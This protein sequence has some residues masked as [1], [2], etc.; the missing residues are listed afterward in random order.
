[1]CFH[2]SNGGTTLPKRPMRIRAHACV[3]LILLFLCS[4]FASELILE[5]AQSLGSR[6]HLLENLPLSQSHERPRR[7]VKS[8]GNVWAGDGFGINL[9]NEFSQASAQ[10]GPSLSVI[11]NLVD[12]ARQPL[13]DNVPVHIEIYNG[14][15]GNIANRDAKGPTHQFD[16]LPWYGNS[17]AMVIINVWRIDNGDEARRIL[18]QRIAGRT[19]RVDLMILPKRPELHALDWQQLQRDRSRIAE[20]FSIGKPIHNPQNSDPY[21]QLASTGTDSLWWL[22]SFL[23]LMETHKVDQGL[24]IDY[25]KGFNWDSASG[26]AEL[27]LWVDPNLVMVWTEKQRYKRN[28]R[29]HLPQLVFGSNNQ[30]QSSK[31]PAAP[32]PT[33]E[34]TLFEDGSYSKWLKSG[35]DGAWERFPPLEP[36]DAI[37]MAALRKKYNKPE[38][39]IFGLPN[40]YYAEWTIQDRRQLPQTSSH[41]NVVFNLLFRA[42]RHRTISGLECIELFILPKAP[43]GADTLF[44]GNEV[45]TTAMY[46]RLWYAAQQNVHWRFNPGFVIRKRNALTFFEAAMDG[47]LDVIKTY[48]STGTDIESESGTHETALELAIKY[49]REETVEF[50][51]ASGAKPNHHAP[52]VIA[53]QTGNLRI[54]RALMARGAERDQKR[55]GFTPLLAA[56][57]AGNREIVDFLIARGASVTQKTDSRMSALELAVKN[58]KIEVIETLLAHGVN[59]NSNSLDGS[60]ILNLAVLANNVR[61]V[62]AFLRGGADPNAQQGSALMVAAYKGHTDVVLALLN[63]GANPN[64]GTG[65]LFMAAADGYTEIVK[66]LLD[67][68]AKPNGL[69][70]NQITPLML[71]SFHGHTEIVNLLLAKGADVNIKDTQYGITAL[72]AAAREGTPDVVQALLAR[73]ADRSVRV[74]GKT[75]LDFAKQSGNREAAAVVNNAAAGRFTLQ[76][77][78]TYSEVGRNP[79]ALRRELLESFLFYDLELLEREASDGKSLQLSESTKGNLK[80]EL[81]F[82]LD[83]IVKLY[84]KNRQKIAKYLNG[85]PLPVLSAFVT[86]TDNGQAYAGSVAPSE[87]QTGGIF[88]D[89]K[90]LKTNM[91]TTL[92]ESF[93][94]SSAISEQEQLQKLREI[95][96][97]V[98]N[99]LVINLGIESN[100]PGAFKGRISN[101][102]ELPRTL[103]QI[104]I[105]TELLDLD[106]QVKRAETQYY[107]TILFVLAHELG[108]LAL[109]HHEAMN[110]A[111]LG[112]VCEIREQIEK[113]ADQFSALLLGSSFIALSVNVLPVEMPG[114]GKSNLRF[115]DNKMLQRYVGYSLFFDKAYERLDLKKPQGDECYPSPED[116]LQTAG[117]AVKS[118][119]DS[120]GESIVNKIQRRQDIKDAVRSAF[121]RRYGL[122]SDMLR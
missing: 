45:S 96:R 77:D 107:G 30:S 87:N 116:R 19:Q 98:R 36:D 58:C 5:R 1:M 115:L 3:C 110:S 40:A 103:E 78:F 79:A 38:R 51:L 16:G 44:Y 2:V 26:N 27:S 71:A 12:G 68:G 105:Y 108:H 37:A 9:N 99:H 20:L 6:E 113:Q 59:A 94:E 76:R 106:Q 13:G 28:L 49:G 92:A 21:D 109:G 23:A 91:V 18:T 100:G 7:L 95:Q 52:L 33:P 102:S 53:A 81:Q 63:H 31:P 86:L 54:V 74:E 15:D 90:L 93:P 60:P 14:F 112:K 65:V 39:R 72:I 34:V 119:K 10:S 17:A 67:H 97:Q 69:D 64:L 73:G 11:L 70:P 42:D 88:I 83:A 104:D 120:E 114:L 62:E 75:A 48:L 117:L 8:A 85:R 24:A 29:T 55:D 43:A 89:A 82:M 46:E 61:C 101:L 32:S 35:V 22:L 84:N 25:I 50:L 47:K 57:Q 4:A 66:A 121:G 122:I 41:E 56:S 118:I 111:P 80:T